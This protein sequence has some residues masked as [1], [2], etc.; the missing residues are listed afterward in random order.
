MLQH[1]TTSEHGLT[2]IYIAGPC[3]NLPDT[4]IS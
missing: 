3:R 1:S 4:R 2:T